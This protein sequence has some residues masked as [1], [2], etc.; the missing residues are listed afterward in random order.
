MVRFKNRYFLLEVVWKEGKVDE[1]L[2]EVGVLKE[3]RD[4]IQENFGDF[5]A[6][7]AMAS[8]LVKYY[9]PLTS[10]CILRCSREQLRQ[11]W[12]AASLITQI[13]RRTVLIQM[14][15]LAGTLQSCQR[16]AVQYN[17]NLMKQLR[18]SRLQQ[19]TASDAHYQLVDLQLLA[20]PCNERSGGGCRIKRCARDKRT[21]NPQVPGSCG[22]WWFAS[23]LRDSSRPVCA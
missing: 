22:L 8:V 5:G 9:N 19:A 18:L 20:I 13:R 12:C 2:D 7:Q 16:A 1:S 4:S 3:L 11:V 23:A 15:K 17:Q 21:N 14:I 6:A 10:L